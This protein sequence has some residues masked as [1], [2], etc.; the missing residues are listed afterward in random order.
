MQKIFSRIPPAVKR[1]IILIAAQSPGGVRFPRIGGERVAD[2]FQIKESRLLKLN[3]GYRRK[4]LLKRMA[5]F[6]ARLLG[7]GAAVAGSGV[8]TWRIYQSCVEP[9]IQESGAYYFPM[10]DRITTGSLFATFGS[11]IIAVFTLYTTRYLSNFQECL[12][13]LMQELA[14]EDTDG[15]LRRRWT[16]IPRVSRTRCAGES[17]YFGIES[18]QIEF[19]IG[20]TFQTFSLPTT[21]ADFKDLPILSSFLYMKLLRKQYLSSLDTAERLA[22][23]PAWDCAAAIYRSILLYKMCYYF[24]WVG[25][26]F[27]FQS[28]LFTFFYSAFYAYL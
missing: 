24:V 25:V 21:E 28:I 19:L 12:L 18:A 16:F 10:I 23:Y 11:A 26:C 3:K 27:V 17:Q 22:E 4:Y 5:S 15:A 20:D 6:A 1:H 13:I 9:V 8:I 2:T 7:V 14:A